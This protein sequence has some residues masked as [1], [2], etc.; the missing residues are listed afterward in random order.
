MFPL[1]IAMAA[2]PELVEMWDG[3]GGSNKY[4]ATS[5]GMNFKSPGI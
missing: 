3:S 1:F 2:A 4:L 5:S